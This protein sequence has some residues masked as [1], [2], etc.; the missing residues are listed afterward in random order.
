[1]VSAQDEL[2]RLG[3]SGVVITTNVP[4]RQ[5]G[6]PYSSARE[7]DDPGVAVYFRLSGAVHCLA[8]DR[9]DRVADNLAAVAHH[10]AAMRGQSRWGVGSVEQAFAGYRAL[11]AAAAKRPWWELLGF[12]QLPARLEIARDAWREWI[13]K[14]HP[15][16]G[17]TANQAAEINAAMAEAERYFTE[18]GST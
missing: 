9:W 14:A 6:L 4:T 17:G 15:D 2:R 8:C 13:F 3:A 10:V 1:V 7:P 11:P 18:E 5:D 12:S 16:R